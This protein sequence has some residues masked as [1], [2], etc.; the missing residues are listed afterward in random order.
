MNLDRRPDRNEWFLKNMEAAGVPMELVERVPAKD[1]RDYD[2][3]EDTVKAMQKDGFAL[4]FPPVGH[5][6]RKGLLHPDQRGV[7]ALYFSWSIILHRI[8]NDDKVTLTFLDDF[9]LLSWE[10]LI[11][12][13]KCFN[14]IKFQLIKLHA[15]SSPPPHHERR[16]N[17]IFNYG[18]YGLSDAALIYS[19]SGANRVFAFQQGINTNLV[20]LELLLPTHFNNDYCFQTREHLRFCH[21]LDS[22]SDLQRHKNPEMLQ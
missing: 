16:F 1:W 6:A 17:D 11:G 20:L 4:N 19:P 8:I 22:H 2:S 21:L 15:G 3:V 12:S 13:L 7:A 10:D 9:C 5:W 18:V 14:D